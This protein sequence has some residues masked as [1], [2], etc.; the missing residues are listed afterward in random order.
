MYSLR[1]RR[2]RLSVS[3]AVVL[4]RNGQGRAVKNTVLQPRSPEIAFWAGVDQAPAVNAISG[5][6]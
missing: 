2:N 1:S 3:R 4:D 5:I 6:D